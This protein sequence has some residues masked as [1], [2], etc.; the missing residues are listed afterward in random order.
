MIMNWKSDFIDLGTVVEGSRNE[1]KFESTKKL[2][3]DSIKAGCGSCTKGTKYTHPYLT[4][5]YTPTGVPKHLKAKG[6]TSYVTTK[7]LTLTYIDGTQELL[8]FK[9]K[10]I[11]K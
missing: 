5:V 8:K 7:F 11:G 4:A 10:V 3:I 9:S 6:K 2:N 1:I